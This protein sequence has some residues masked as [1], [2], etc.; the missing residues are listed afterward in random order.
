M[1]VSQY[2]ILMVIYDS[3]RVDRREIKEL[4]W[5]S[6]SYGD[7]IL[8]IDRLQFQKMTVFLASLRFVSNVPIFYTSRVVQPIDRPLNK[9]T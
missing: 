1:S 3:S 5:I 7:V 6:I 8:T 4:K 9:G 2:L